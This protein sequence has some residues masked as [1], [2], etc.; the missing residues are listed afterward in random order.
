MLLC[1]SCKIEKPTTE[2]SKHS[3]WARGYQYSCKECANKARKEWRKKGDNRKRE[4]LTTDRSYMLKTYGM[5]FDDYL[6][7]LAQ[8]GNKCFICDV[9]YDEYIAKEKRRFAID[10]DHSVTP[11][12]IRSLLCHRCNTAIGLLDHNIKRLEQ[13]IAYLEYHEDD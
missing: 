10:A 2:F 4:A 6:D 9:D 11:I 8:Q 13:A 12:K 5:T 7:M 3:T 1:T